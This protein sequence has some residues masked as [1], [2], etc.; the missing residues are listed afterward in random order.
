[1]AATAQKMSR[2]SA[3]AI[4]L[5]WLIGLLIVGMI[6][7]GFWMAGA[8]EDPARRAVAFEVVQLHKSI[9]LTI[10]VLTGVRLVWRLAHKPPALPSHMSALEKGAARVSHL[11][12][13]ILMLALPLTGWAMVSA[14]PW[15]LPTMYF[16]L[17]EWPHI[18]PLTEVADKKAVSHLF[19]EI[20]EVLA[21]GTLGLLALH[22]LAALKH[23]FF[24][25]D[26]VLARMVPG[27]KVR[28]D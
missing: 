16:G 10:L 25:K 2:Y 1:M 7:V 27:L 4:F 5:H 24:D 28:R 21:F 14:S 6:A 26:D 11:G 8:L 23:H 15:G 18:A 20:H 13:Y 17:F 19:E 12:F 22:I 9:G 3:V